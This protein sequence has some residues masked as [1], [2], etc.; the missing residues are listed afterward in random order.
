MLN[1][2]SALTRTRATRVGAMLAGMAATLAIMAPG[3][4]HALTGFCE[5][6]KIGPGGT[7]ESSPWG[8]VTT[9]FAEVTSG[10]GEICAA[11]VEKS[12]VRVGRR[13]AVNRVN[14]QEGVGGSEAKAQI[15]NVSKSTLTVFGSYIP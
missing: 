4:A 15:Q 13:C 10:S 1:A 14:S 3:Q 5:F 8:P 6:A 12:G 2:V 9:V 11:V 7:C